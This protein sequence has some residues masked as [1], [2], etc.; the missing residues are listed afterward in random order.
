MILL[1]CVFYRAPL[2]FLFGFFLSIFL[3]VVGTG[4]ELLYCNISTGK[5]LTLI[6]SGIMLMILSVVMSVFYLKKMAQ[7][8]RNTNYFQYHVK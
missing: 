6:I 2:I 5:I 8:Y 7:S 4:C 3:L 1:E